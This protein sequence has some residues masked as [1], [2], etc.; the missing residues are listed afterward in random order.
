MSDSSLSVETIFAAMGDSLPRRFPPKVVVMNVAGKIFVIDA[1]EGTVRQVDAAPK[2]ADLL[3]KTT[4]E[5][6]LKLLQKKLT[7]QQAFLKGLLKVKGN[8]AL[9]MKLTML[10]DATRNQLQPKSKL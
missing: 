3:V 10:L 7:P 5:T 6:L 1:K 8:M 2:K 4:L 9:A